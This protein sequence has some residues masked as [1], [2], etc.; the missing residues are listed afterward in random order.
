[1][2]KKKIIE[3]LA[4]ERINELDKGLFIVEITISSS[5]VI[6]VELDVENGNVA[7]NDCVSVS[8]NI[9][10]NLDREEQ[11]FE[12]SVSSAGLD[13]PFRVL[14]QYTKNIGNEV[15]VQLKEKNN[16]IEGVLTHADEKGIKLETTTKERVEGKKK[17]EII[18]REHE[19]TFDE[20]K[21]TKIVISF[22][23]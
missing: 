21:E 16:T 2:L 12:L 8:R 23:K 14:Q 13:K 20:I 5:N 7:I 17:K 11:D 3:E 18:V 4:L 22:K 15:K 10:H 9:E 6:Q 19:F 1:M